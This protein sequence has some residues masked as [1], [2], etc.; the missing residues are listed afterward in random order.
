M[1]KLIIQGEKL[2]TGTARAN[3]NSVCLIRVLDFGF[4]IWAL[5]GRVLSPVSD[6][7]R[8]FFLFFPAFLA[9]MGHPVK[10]GALKWSHQVTGL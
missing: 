10:T 6:S 3:K 7:L 5:C 8:D 2:K 4:P 1:M 9:V